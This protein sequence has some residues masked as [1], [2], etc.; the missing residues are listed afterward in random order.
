MAAWA[1]SAVSK[2]AAVAINPALNALRQQVGRRGASQIAGQVSLPS[3]KEF[4]EA[5]V[6]ISEQPGTLPGFLAHHAKRALSDIPDVFQDENVRLWLQRDDVRSQVI[7]GARA[8]IAGRL[9]DVERQAATASFV[10]NLG[11][12]AWWGEFVFDCAV[13]FLSLT[14]KTKMDAGQRAIIDN[15]NFNTE[16]LS[17]QISGLSASVLPQSPEAIRAYIEPQIRREERERSLVDDQRQDRLVNLARRAIEGDLQAAEQD[18]RI[19]LFRSTA[20][21]LARAGRCDE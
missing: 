17:Q 18:I 3:A 9:A 15:G 5:L 12:F 7:E 1:T 14:I 11:D 2:A 20:A 8:A 19:A 21:A 4:E 13:A 16:L 6:L 10:E